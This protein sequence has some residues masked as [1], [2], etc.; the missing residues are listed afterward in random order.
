MMKWRLVHY[1]Q[2]KLGVKDE[3]IFIVGVDAT[4]DA[5]EYLG[6]KAW[7]RRFSNLLK[8]RVPLVRTLIKSLKAKKV[9]TNPT[10]TGW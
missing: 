3:D 9:E 5:L 1:L 8:V 2:R 10:V 4:P 7:M 6:K